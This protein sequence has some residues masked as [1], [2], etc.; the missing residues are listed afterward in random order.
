MHHGAVNVGAGCVNV[1]LKAH[2]VGSRLLYTRPA[3][4]R[5]GLEVVQQP[6][7]ACAEPQHI[8]R[9][10]L[11]AVGRQGD[12]LRVREVLRE[13]EGRQREEVRPLVSRQIRSDLIREAVDVYKRQTGMYFSRYPSILSIAPLAP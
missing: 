12:G 7:E 6:V 5:V 13:I 8:G 4:R 1:F 2:L 10:G 3:L 11:G 9:Q